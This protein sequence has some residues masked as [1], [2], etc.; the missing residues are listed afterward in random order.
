MISSRISLGSFRDW[1]SGVYRINI[2]VGRPQRRVIYRRMWP[3]PDPKVLALS[4]GF[5][6]WPSLSTA[7]RAQ[8]VACNLVLWFLVKKFEGRYWRCPL[9]YRIDEYSV[10]VQQ[11][12]LRIYISSGAL[13]SFW[14]LIDRLWLTWS[15]C[16]NWCH[17]L[18]WLC[19]A[20]T[21]ASTRWLRPLQPMYSL[22]TLVF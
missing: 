8:F 16:A 6:P 4:Q 14:R 12:G 2:S 15:S 11:H 18:W 7:M 17:W 21:Q 20:Q 1:R 3:Q 9:N 13:Q 22:L 5:L 19:S 10:L